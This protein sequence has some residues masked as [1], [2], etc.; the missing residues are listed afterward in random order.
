MPAQDF[1]R[2]FA[3][4][5]W[6]KK[7]CSVATGFDFPGAPSAEELFHLTLRACW[8][9][10][11]LGRPRVFFDGLGSADKRLWPTPE[12]RGFQHYEERVRRQNGDRPFLLV[13]N[14]LQAFDADRWDAV[15]R[16]L[17]PLF[18][19][20]GIPS[21]NVEL[22]VFVGTYPKTPF[23][24]HRDTAS[25]MHFPVIGTKRI[26][27][28]PSTFVEQ[29]PEIKNA[30]DYPDLLEGSELLEA[31][32]GGML[33]WPSDSWHVGEGDGDLSVTWGVG[34][35]HRPVREHVMRLAER[36]ITQAMGHD[37]VM[38]DVT[39]S[40]ET[41]RS[42]QPADL[43]PLMQEVRRVMTDEV[44]APAA[45]E[46]VAVVDWLKRRTAWGFTAVPL[47]LSG[48][49]LSAEDVVREDEVF[50]ILRARSGGRIWIAANGHAFSVSEHPVVDAMLDALATGEPFRVGA[51]VERF[52]TSTVIDGHEWVA[53]PET[54]VDL[55]TTL[56]SLRGL[57]RE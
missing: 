40:F 55:L 26:R 46:Q 31:G 39:M 32:P 50:P 6:E 44:F 16:L 12:D 22:S 13:V 4:R 45:I 28:W 8:Q 42:L 14:N 3:A 52:A 19:E 57:L 2:D 36:L 53:E 17:K 38:S 24:V 15:R 25:V 35:W 20:V 47:P 54:I 37:E 27:T 1:W 48:V 10:E 5:C 9:R 41:K 18:D 49:S 56:C 33:Y 43:P 30:V 51:L 7:G 34:C 21:W 23:G 11:P 29:H